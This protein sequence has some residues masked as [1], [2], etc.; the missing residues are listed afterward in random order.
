MPWGWGG[1]VRGVRSAQQCSHV[2][3]HNSPV[4]R[5]LN[6]QGRRA[7]S[8]PAQVWLGRTRTG[9][10]KALGTI[11][12]ADSKGK[13]SRVEPEPAPCAPG[14]RFRNHRIHFWFVV[15]ETDHTQKNAYKW[16]LYVYIYY[17]IFLFNG[18][19]SLDN[20]LHIRIYVYSS[21]CILYT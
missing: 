17:S 1:S 14:A 4:T 18:Y 11:R 7:A 15:W 19:Y 9:T 13:G 21:P 3:Q 5:S 2:C 12:G 16:I 10:N 6:I 20:V 8:N